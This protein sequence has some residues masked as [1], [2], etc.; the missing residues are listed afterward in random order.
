MALKHPSLAA[1]RTDVCEYFG[2]IKE[3]VSACSAFAPSGCWNS[4]LEILRLFVDFRGLQTSRAIWSLWSDKSSKAGYTATD[5]TVEFVKDA[6]KAAKLPLT[7]K[8][9]FDLASADRLGSICA[10]CE[11]CIAASAP[12]G[13]LN[14][15]R[16]S[17]SASSRRTRAACTRP[18]WSCSRAR[19]G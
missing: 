3:R 17:I 7:K 11:C 6:C 4:R 1:L 16:R 9:S 8:V 15:C 14:D 19:A 10:R 13:G 12:G 18:S 5:T 2:D